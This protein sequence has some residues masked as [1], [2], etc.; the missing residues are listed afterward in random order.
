MERKASGVLPLR[1]PDDELSGGDVPFAAAAQTA[2]GERRQMAASL[3]LNLDSAAR[4]ACPHCGETDENVGMA[5][6]LTV[7]PIPDGMQMFLVRPNAT[8]RTVVDDVR[9]ALINGA[10]E[11]ADGN[12]ARAA[13]L[14]GMKY[15]TFHTLA[16]RLGIA[17]RR[18]G[19]EAELEGN[20]APPA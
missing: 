16:R 4:I 18:P 12:Q 14:L 1:V 10:L 15:T 20:G 11:R 17:W 13:K 3:Q 19:D 6:N 9:R 7:G 2:T 8:L 5:L